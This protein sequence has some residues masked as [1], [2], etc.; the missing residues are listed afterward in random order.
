MNLSEQLRRYL[1]VLSFLL[2]GILIFYIASKQKKFSCDDWANDFKN[3]FQCRLVL[4][5][6]EYGGGIATLTGVDL[7]SNKVIA[8]EDGSKWIIDNFEKFNIGDTVIKDKGKYTILIK[9][10]RQ[11]IIIQMTCN[12]K[13]YT[14]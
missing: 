1:S 12:D 9:R 3:N 13:V 2:V 8:V 4:T 10:N 11:K 14:D 7:K 5:K 6:K